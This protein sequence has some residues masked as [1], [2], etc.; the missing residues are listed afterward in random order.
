[1]QVQACVSISY[2]CLN[3]IT[4]LLLPSFLDVFF[5]LVHG[6]PM[7]STIW[8]LQLALTIQKWLLMVYLVKFV[9][10]DDRNDLLIVVSGS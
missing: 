7:R 5:L 2:G 8:N 1:M 3:F 4:C 6:G 9:I 10:F